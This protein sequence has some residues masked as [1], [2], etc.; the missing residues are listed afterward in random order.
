MRILASLALVLVAVAA[1][2]A[3]DPFKD[4]GLEQEQWQNALVSVARGSYAPPQIPQSLRALD[5]PSRAAVV[6]ALGAFARTYTA[7]GDFKKRH[8]KPWKEQ[9]GGGGGGFGLGGLKR[10]MKGAAIDAAKDAATGG[11]EPSDKPED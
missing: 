5:G 6:E 8:D 11:A 10:K 9:N 3:V 1:F 2:A 7:S 4:Y